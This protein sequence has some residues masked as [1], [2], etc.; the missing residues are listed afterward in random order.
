MKVTIFGTGY[1]GLVTGACLAEVG[2]ELLCVD[3]D[4]A[5]IEGLQNGV[6]PIYEPGLE[7]MDKHNAGEGRLQLCT[8]PSAVVS[9]YAVPT[10]VGRVLIRDPLH[11]VFSVDGEANHQGWR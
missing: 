2:N 9:Q 1:V 7:A 10:S 11:S 5:K 6:I 8:D 3:I 4:T